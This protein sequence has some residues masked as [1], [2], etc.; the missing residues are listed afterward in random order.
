MDLDYREIFEKIG[1]SLYRLA[2]SYVKSASD[3]EDVTQEAF[4]RLFNSDR[5]FQ[6][7]EDVK[8][9]LMTVTANRCRD[10]LR[11]A[12]RRKEVSIETTL[13]EP[14]E[15]AQLDT[16]LDIGTALFRLEEKYR[17]VIYLYYYEGYATKDVSRILHITQSAVLSRLERARK[18]LQELLGGDWLEG[19]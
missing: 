1:P 2:Y 6:T 11:S 5:R 8:R 16:Q 13:P 9:W 19:S 3:A 7:M 4:L 10:L 12:R 17:V 18:K 15:A 14:T